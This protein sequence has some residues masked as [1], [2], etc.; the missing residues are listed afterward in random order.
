MA[1]WTSLAADPQWWAVA[2]MPGLFAAQAYRRGHFQ[3]LWCAVLVWLGVG[4]ISA[5]LLPKI[6]GITH[7]ANLYLP[8]FYL[9]IGSVFFFLNQVHTETLPSGR[10]YWT[11]RNGDVL[12]SLFAWANL[13]LHA[14]W[15]WWGL[16]CYAMGGVSAYVPVHWLAVYF[17]SPLNWLLMLAVLMGVFYLHRRASQ[18][19]ADWVSLRQLAGGVVLAFLLVSM[20]VGASLAGIWAAG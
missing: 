4:L 11:S 7:L 17:A 16:Y 18:Q 3:W 15:A 20:S 19:R 9:F 12:L 5:M 14:A 6:L 10:R 8:H 1:D 13:V 2:L